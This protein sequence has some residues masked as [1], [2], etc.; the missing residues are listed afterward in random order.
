MKTFLRYSKIFSVRMIL[1]ISVSLFILPVKTNAQTFVFDGGRQKDA[2][3][4]QLV[5]N[6]VIIPLY[7]NGKGPFNFILDTG[8]GP[9]IISDPSTVDSLNVQ[10]LRS[11]K[12]SGLG[13]GSDIDAYLSDAISVRIG[14]SSMNNMPTA[15]LKEDIFNLSS[16]TGVHISGLIGY[17]FFNSFIVKIRYPSKKLIFS[18]PQARLKLKGERL[19]MEMINNKPYITA[20]IGKD[21]DEK[22]TVKLI[23]DIGASHALSMESYNEEPYPLPKETIK[24]N[25]G[26]GFTGLISGSIGRVK[27][28]EIAS[29]TFK[30]VLTSF[31]IYEDAAAKTLVK[32]RNG[33]LGSN[34]ARH[35]DITF[36]YQD[37][38][39]YLRPNNYYKKN[40]EHDMSGMEVY[41]EEGKPNRY[42]VG[43]IEPGSPAELTDIQPLDELLTIN[44][45]SVSDYTLDDIDQLF[46]SGNGRRI[47]IE[48]SRKN[49]RFFR[50]LILKRR[51]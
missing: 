8:V 51:I 9:M 47:I 50:M 36:D 25:L 6:L 37:F 11:T 38:S 10:S 32:E 14:N 26:M 5:K 21:N 3:N 18:L 19:P 7:I 24:A 41:L 49:K 42:L 23:F 17:Y 43:R 13:A 28:L 46:K 16:Y 2:L 40:F 34:L 39:V 45:K 31:P 4:F 30:N 1:G 15:I 48:L 44:L 33:N 35:F 22:Q 12:I 20:R 27:T 29:T